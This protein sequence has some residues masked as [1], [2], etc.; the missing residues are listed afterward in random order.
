[1]LDYKK[2][3]QVNENI[4]LNKDFDIEKSEEIKEAVY[5]IECQ[6]SNKGRVILRP[7]GTEPLVRI[8]IEGEDQEQLDALLG[9]LKAE[10][11]AI[12]N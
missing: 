7:S 2:L 5:K 4:K 9:Q 8:M 12:I 3:P 10:V 1:M 11:N 6:L